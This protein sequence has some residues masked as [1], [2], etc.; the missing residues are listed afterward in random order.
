MAILGKEL[1]EWI[2]ASVEDDELYAIDDGGLTLCL[3]RDPEKC[4]LEIGGI[5]EEDN[6]SPSSKATIESLT[7]AV[8][9]D[10]VRLRE[11][12]YANGRMALRVITATT[13]EPYATLTVNVPEAMIAEDELIVKAWG[14][15]EDVARAALATG[16]FVDTG[17][18]LSTGF[19]EA[20]V[21]KLT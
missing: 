16:L 9:K 17:R 19:M 4:Y 2:L 15:N 1:R 20:Q 10:M 8:G 5:P 11:Y 14:E 3:A 18:R 12:Q 7:F 6:D 21:W 13:G